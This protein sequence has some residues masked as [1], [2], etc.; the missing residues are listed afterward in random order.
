LAAGSAAGALAGVYLLAK[1]RAGLKSE[2]PFGPFLAL[3]VA[4]SA[5][6]GDLFLSWYDGL[7]YL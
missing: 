4:A 6:Y 5:L 3:G 7:F 1:K 2:I